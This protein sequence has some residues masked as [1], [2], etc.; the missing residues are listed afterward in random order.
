MSFVWVLSEVLVSDITSTLSARLITDRISTF[1]D[2]ISLNWCGHLVII[3]NLLGTDAN[4]I[5]RVSEHKAVKSSDSTPPLY[6]NITEQ[7]PLTDT[8]YET[9]NQ[10]HRQQSE[11][12]LHGILMMGVDVC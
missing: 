10:N 3:D 6:Q 7:I 2:L 5:P 11:L 1:I 8:Q 12:V 4:Y 9:A